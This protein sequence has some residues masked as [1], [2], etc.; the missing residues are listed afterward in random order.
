MTCSDLFVFI[1]QLA[2]RR[3][4][5]IVSKY[6]AIFVKSEQSEH[7]RGG[8]YSSFRLFWCLMHKTTERLSIQTFGPIKLQTYV[9]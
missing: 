2:V 8:S 6:E 4:A 3:V 5:E 7:T 9:N 1:L